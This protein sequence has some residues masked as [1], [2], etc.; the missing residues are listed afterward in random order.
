MSLHRSSAALAALLAVSVLL[1]LR[2]CTADTDDHKIHKPIVARVR[3]DATTSLYTIAIKVGGVPLLL[4]LAG[5]LLWLAN[6]PTPHRTIACDDDNC[7]LANEYHPP[8]CPY[9]P[10]TACSKG[11]ACTAYPYNPINGRCADDDAT[12]ITLAANATDGKNPLFPVSFRAA[13]SCAPGELLASLP[14]GTAGV[15]GLSRLT[16]SLPS[17]FASILGV[18]KQ[19]ALCL[20]GGSG[21]DGVAV[22]GGG[23]F[24]L[25]AAPPVE[26]ASGILENQ[27][28]LLTNPKINNGAYYF[29]ITGMAVNEQKV[30][31]PPGAFDLDP[32]SGTGGAIFSTV[33]PYTALRTDIYRPLHESFDA[34]TSGIARA[35][36]VAPFDMCYQAS[37]LGVTRLGYAVANI[38]LMLEGRRNWTLPGGSSLVQVN[39]N[40]VCF[41]FVEMGASMP[42]AA[43]SPAVILGSFQMAEHLLIFDLNNGTF[44]FSALLSGIRTGCSNFNFTMGSSS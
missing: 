23:P 14:A 17:Q 2:P 36:P 1:G 31:T 13:G 22:F 18:A 44:G 7:K 11:V 5:P 32:Q 8:N 9:A 27:L 10:S 6:C 35:Q 3:K 15:A 24:Q 29:G 26:L 39:D 38:D 4:D 34:A 33:T 12:T 40:T 21:S 42:A 43:N 37:A 41:A 19:F 25:L 16:L 30:P 28:P 20:P